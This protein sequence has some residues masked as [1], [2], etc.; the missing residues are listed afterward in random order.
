MPLLAKDTYSGYLMIKTNNFMPCGGQSL[1]LSSF[2]SAL[3]KKSSSASKM[4]EEGKSIQ[5]CIYV[6]KNKD[7]NDSLR[8]WS[9]SKTIFTI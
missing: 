1:L 2:E 4:R 3:L 6:Y 8:F 7:I 9:P 5:L